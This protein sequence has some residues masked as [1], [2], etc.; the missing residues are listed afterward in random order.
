LGAHHP[1]DFEAIDHV[2]HGRQHLAGELE[3][4]QTQRPALARRAEPAKEKAQ[5]LPERIK[6]E[7]A[8]HHRIALEVAGEEPEVRPYIEHRAHQ[9]LTVLAAPFRD[10]GNAIEHQQ[11]WQR[12][13][14]PLG[15]QVAAAAGQQVL[16]LEAIASVIHCR[17]ACP[18][19]WLLYSCGARDEIGPNPG[20][21]RPKTPWVSYRRGCC[22]TI[23]T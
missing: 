20:I 7:A 3:L 9:A 13:L 8:W 23:A 11:R 22:E 4:A 21:A 12:K 15:E 5:Q 2:L 18:P 14:R 16:E 17:P 6:A 1:L 10:L 19:G